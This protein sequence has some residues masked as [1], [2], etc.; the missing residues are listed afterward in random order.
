MEI[1]CHEI[2][3]A[4]PWTFF[5]DEKAP[6][7][8][9]LGATNAQTQVFVFQFTLWISKH[10]SNYSKN[11]A[12]TRERYDSKN[13]VM[14]RER[15]WEDAANHESIIYKLEKEKK[16]K[17]MQIWYKNK[18]T[19]EQKQPHVS[20]WNYSRPQGLPWSYTNIVFFPRMVEFSKPP[21]YQAKF[22]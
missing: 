5:P 15:E 10:I 21:V 1:G 16:E 19:K 9:V 11:I 2:W 7:F 20:F 14:P 13:I 3:N 4:P 6:L 22:S 8:K 12:M 17:Q 18:G